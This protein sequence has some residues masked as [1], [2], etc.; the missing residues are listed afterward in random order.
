MEID[1]RSLNSVVDRQSKCTPVNL[2]NLSYPNVSMHIIYT[3]LCTKVLTRSIC[4]SLNS[5]VDRQSKCTP[6]NLS[7]LSYPNVSIHIVYTVLCTKV[8]TRSI[9]VRIKSFVSW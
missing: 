3:V 6:V 2:S 5:V 4:V 9:C 7:N 1:E 8:L